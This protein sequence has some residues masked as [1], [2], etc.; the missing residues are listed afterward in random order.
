MQRLVVDVDEQ[1][2]NLVVDLLSNLKENIIKNIS[3]EKNY[4]QPI[5]K[6]SSQL[7]RFYEL[8]GKS[9]NQIP[10]TMKIATDTSGMVD[11]GLF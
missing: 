3:I 5:S 6:K 4:I 7:N 1:H 10:L 8:I 11:D 9:N 2:M